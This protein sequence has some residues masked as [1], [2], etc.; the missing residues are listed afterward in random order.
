MRRELKERLADATRWK[1]RSRGGAIRQTRAAGAAI[2]GFLP[3]NRQQ[4]DEVPVTI[5]TPV[6]SRDWGQLLGPGRERELRDRRELGAGGAA[7]G[8][9]GQAIVERRDP[10]G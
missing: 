9:H 2:R 6:P 5:M 4:A 1:P 7:G 10:A 3:K 8:L